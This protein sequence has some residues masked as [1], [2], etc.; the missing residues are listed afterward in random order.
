MEGTPVRQLGPRR[1]THCG[2]DFPTG[3]AIHGGQRGKEEGRFATWHFGSWA[4][5]TICLLCISGAPLYIMLA[6]N[7]TKQL[8]IHSMLLPIHF[9]FTYYGCCKYSP[10]HLLHLV[11]YEAVKSGA[12]MGCVGGVYP[13]T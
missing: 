8:G 10:L 13:H 3:R 11:L 6:V 12:V 5:K 2:E 1:K 9:V 7:L 4:S